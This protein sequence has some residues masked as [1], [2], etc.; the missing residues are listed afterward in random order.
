MYPAVNTKDPAA[1]AREAQTIYQTL[2]PEADPLF[3]SRAFS[4]TI[5]CFAGQHEDYLPIDARYHDLEHTLQGT[6]CMVRLLHGWHLNGQPRLTPRLFQLGL[7]AILF[8]D[9]GYL[10]KRTDTEGTGAK[11]TAIHVHR[12]ADFASRFLHAKGYPPAD[13]RA[14]Q[15][16]IR[17]TGVDVDLTAIPFSDE[18]EQLT[19][20][21]LGTADLLGQMSAPD[22]VEKLP[23]LYAEFAEAGRHPTGVKAHLPGFA[24]AAELIRHTPAFW[25]EFVRP[26]IERDFRG[27]YRFLNDPWPDG[28]NPYVERVE[29]NIA[30]IRQETAAG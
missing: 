10:K 14:V 18:R 30:R 3:V 7:L 1:V 29:A 22:Y 11:Y 2:F 9:T 4:W 25:T 5:E 12:S 17:C 16:M 26:R 6:L 27:L 20:F 21:A 19:G 28:P 8:H 15:H 24:S 23:I 13:I